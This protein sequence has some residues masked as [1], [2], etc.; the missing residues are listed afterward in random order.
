[1]SLFIEPSNTT[2]KLNV[3]T[4]AHKLHGIL[5]NLIKNA[6]KYTDKGEITI[7]YFLKEN[8]VEFNIKDTGIGIPKNRITSIFNR[9]EQ[10]DIEDSRVFEGSGLGLAISKAYITMLGGTISVQST[11]GE[12]SIFTFTI[13]HTQKIKKESASLHNTVKFN[14]S[15]IKNL[16]LLIVEDDIVSSYFLETIL[17]EEFKKITVVDNGKKAIEYCK[18]NSEVDLILMDIKMPILNGYDATIEIRKFNKEVLIIA[19]TAY[20]MPGDKEKAMEVGCDEY[21][22]KPINKDFLLKTIDTLFVK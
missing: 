4:D 8:C 19:Q 7:G 10:A 18:N 21:V 6:I 11:E 13:P 20:A 16:N 12:G 15:I 22:V 3:T 17:N 14:N 1:M 2:E 9:F 5:T